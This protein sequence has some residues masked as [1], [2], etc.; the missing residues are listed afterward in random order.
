MKKLVDTYQPKLTPEEEAYINNETNGLCAVINDD[1]V[2]SKRDFSKEAWDYMRDNKFFGLKIP[3]EWGG[4]GFS[5]QAVSVILAKLA[6][7]CVDA[8]ATVA[9]PNSLGPGELLVRYG[10]QEQKEYFLPR[11]ADGTLIP[12]FGL[13]GPHSGS[14]ATSL[15]G[16][17]GVVEERDGV[18]GVR[19]TFKKR[20]ITL[21][22]VA[23]VVGIGFNLSDPNGL[24]K[25]NGTEGFS[26]ALL[27]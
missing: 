2:T 3:K 8:N 13:T 17:D 5:T 20:Y 18:L 22:P 6:V 12:C 24:L 15:I 16:S 11:L 25:G 1:E 26:V 7:H 9:V 4:L 10:T 21:A 14:D 27:E 19:T 23:G